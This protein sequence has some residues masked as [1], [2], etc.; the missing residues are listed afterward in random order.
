[1]IW[2]CVIAVLIA[3]AGFVA[4]GFPG[5]LVLGAAVPVSGLFTPNELG[6]DQVWPTAIGISVVGPFA[7]VP[8]YFAMTWLTSSRLAR[9]LGTAAGT[10]LVNLLATVAGIVLAV[11]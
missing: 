9:G 8:S 7:L 1:M 4:L 5:L 10:L 2:P 3:V 6:P 11:R